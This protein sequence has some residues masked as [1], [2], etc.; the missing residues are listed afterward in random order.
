MLVRFGL[1]IQIQIQMLFGFVN[2]MLNMLH[3]N[4]YG[5]IGVFKKINN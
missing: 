1:L 2:S 5:F 4:V 3:L